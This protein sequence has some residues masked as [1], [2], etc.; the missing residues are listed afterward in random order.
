MMKFLSRL[1]ISGRHLPLKVAV[2]TKQVSAH[3]CKFSKVQNGPRFA[4]GFQPSVHI[5]YYIT[6]LCRQQPEVIQN[7][8]NEHVRRTG[9]GEAKQRKYKRL[10]LDGGQAYD[11]TSD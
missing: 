3:H 9:Q 5:Y 1:G 7:H 11:R 6:G 10:K 4:H 2:P 8:V